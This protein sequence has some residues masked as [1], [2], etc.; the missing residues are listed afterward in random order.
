M[1]DEELKNIRDALRAHVEALAVDIGPRGSALDR[2]DYGE[3]ALWC[4][5]RREAFAFR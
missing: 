4:L 2:F 1:V 5:A 3:P